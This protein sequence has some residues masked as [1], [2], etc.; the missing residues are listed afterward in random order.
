MS[1][2]ADTQEPVAMDVEDGTSPKDASFID[3]LSEPW[4]SITSKVIPPADATEPL[5]QASDRLEQLEIDSRFHMFELL[6]DPKRNNAETIG[7]CWKS[8]LNLC[9]HMVHFA[10]S[11]S[12]Q[13]DPRYADIEPRKLPL[14]LMEDCFDGL[15]LTECK[16]FWSNYIEPALDI[17]LGDLF[18][19]SSNACR[20]QFLRV[21]NLFLNRM[22]A[23]NY[24]WKGRIMM[25]LA[26]GFS[27]AD[28]S[29]LKMWG[30]FHT[31]NNNDF[32][33]QEEFEATEKASSA[34]SSSADYNLYRAFWSLQSDFSNP[35]RIQVADF[36][37]KMK[38]VLDALESAASNKET[39]PIPSSMSHRYLTSSNLFLTQLDTLQ[40]RNCVISQ[41]LIV[42]AH[43][44]AES[45]S[46]GNAL[47]TLL[48]RARKL[49]Q[50][51]NPQLYTI[52]WD[53]ILS[54]RE[55][56]WRKWKKVN[57]CAA[58]AFAP[59][60]KLEEA[61][62]D[63][64]KKKRSGLLDGPLGGGDDGNDSK[65]YEILE[66]DELIKISQELGQA[67]PTLEKHLED[68][69]D[70]LDPEAG[71]E[72]AYHPKNDA[73]FTWR[74]MRLYAK[75]QLPLLKKCRKP[76]D[77]ERMTRQWYLDQGKEIPGEMPASDP[78]SDDESIGSKDSTK[79]STGDKNESEDESMEP[80]NNNDTPAKNDVEN[81][82]PAKND[83]EMKDTDKVVEPG[84]EE[85]PNKEE[86]DD[87]NAVVEAE[88]AATPRESNVS[89]D[90]KAG[91]DTEK[92][93]EMKDT[94]KDYEETNRKE[95]EDVEDE[96]T[97]ETTASMEN[98]NRNETDSV[99]SETSVKQ[100]EDTNTTD[101]DGDDEK[102][103]VVDLPADSNPP[104]RP[105]SED[106]TG[107][108]DAKGQSEIASRRKSRSSSRDRSKSS[109]RSKENR[110]RESGNTGRGHDRSN[111]RRG[112][113]RGRSVEGQRGGRRDDRYDDG[114]KEG[115]RDDRYDDG[116]RGGRRDDRYDDGPRG[117]GRGDRHGDGPRGGRRDDR[118]DDGPRG[119]RRD[120]RLDDGPRGGR[121][122]ERFDD[123]PRG[124]R[125]GRGGSR[126]GVRG[127]GD[128]RDERRGDDRRRG[129]GGGRGRR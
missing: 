96:D 93:E 112:S 66:K 6:R 83:V 10:S 69:V 11:K 114:P 26:K 27:I 39:M 60:R 54:K 22:E 72:D 88:N 53:S 117:G 95:E 118:H 107:K 109:K 98:E 5:A 42:A 29:A 48:L 90:Q 121:R 119:G 67:A 45:A 50:T 13:K 52:L 77:L 55:M 76:A 20:L 24:E 123:G 75:H 12:L 1:A 124:G 38:V 21:C 41:F 28:R 110:S 108:G 86:A 129:G 49:L 46:L 36:I 84:D 34:S 35:N 103:D 30:N 81:E 40:F 92:D 18:W 25:A 59:K 126:G 32:E 37:N 99:T 9:F 71:I 44:T 19:S 43:L 64:Q 105:E 73:M 79:S 51:D 56:Q 8:A 15:T 89:L 102:V 87:T 68:Y 14:V 58:S 2:V 4:K 17:L 65:Q 61:T 113:R 125:G 97:E 100:E 80:E 127:G 7:E 16:K 82:T 33:T 70:A 122:E 47:S 101:V 57:K 63:Q 116:P 104:S 115:R 120:E 111:N 78:E 94:I 85:A 62:E 74:A 31:S 128:R 91:D 23:T 3:S 106:E